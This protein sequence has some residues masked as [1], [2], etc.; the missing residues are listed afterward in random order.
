MSQEVDLHFQYVIPADT[1]L[2]TARTMAA[3]AI[4][5]EMDVGKAVLELTEIAQKTQAALTGK[6]GKQNYKLEVYFDYNFG[7]SLEAAKRL[8]SSAVDEVYNVAK[9]LINQ[10]EAVGESRASFL[11]A[12]KKK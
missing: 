8:L 9:C 6:A 1:V 5:D 4:Q 3:S 2:A 12:T 11:A 10:F 7:G